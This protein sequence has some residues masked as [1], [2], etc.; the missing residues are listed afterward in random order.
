MKL[1]VVFAFVF[2]FAFSCVNSSVVCAP[3]LDVLVCFVRTTDSTLIQETIATQISSGETKLEIRVQPEGLGVVLNITSPEEITD[4]TIINNSAGDIYIE[5]YTFNSGVVTLSFSGYT[6]VV[7]QNLFFTYFPNLEIFEASEVGATSFPLFTQNKKLIE[8]NIGY[9]AIVNES[10]RVINKNAFAGL[11]KLS[12]LKIT[13]MGITEIKGGSFK[14]LTNLRELYLEYNEIKSLESCMF[15]GLENLLTMSLYGNGINSV[16]SNAFLGLSKLSKLVLSQNPSMQ[17]TSVTAL[18][19]LQLLQLSEQNSTSVLPE[20]IQQMTNLTTLDLYSVVFNCT[21][22]TEWLSK[23]AS[24]DISVSFGST[25]CLGD[26]QVASEPLL[27]SS[28]PDRSFQ[29]F[30]NSIECV[31]ENWNRVA[32]PDGCDCVYPNES[33]TVSQICNDTNECEDSSICQ[34]NCINTIGSYRCACLEGFYKMNDTLCVDINECLLAN[35]NCT[36]NCSNT[37][38][39]YECS[40]V[41]GYQKIGSFGCVDIN[42]CLLA[43]GNCTH[44]CS[45][46]LGSYECSCIVGYQKMGS[47]D[48]VDINECLLNNGNCTHICSNTLGSYECSCVVGYQK[49][50]S[51]GCIDINECLL[52]NGNCTHNCSNT[53]GSYEC[54]CLPGYMQFGSTECSL[55]NTCS[56]NSGGCHHNCIDSLDGYVCSCLEGF[57]VSLLNSSHCEV[58]AVTGNNANSKELSFYALFFICFLFLATI[59]LLF[60]FLIIL[61]LYSRKQLQ[62]V[63]AKLASKGVVLTQLEAKPETASPQLDSSPNQ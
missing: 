40:C 25:T 44:N 29:C 53:M 28:C 18:K 62:S 36:H 23:L 54:S 16:H 8:I 19:A 11:D 35:G 5:A 20:I 3:N 13:S 34:G 9:G 22:D 39:S 51:S 48:C 30:N 58:D 56:H 47:Y 43:N 42:E 55:P 1:T 32:T 38:G 7:R 37:L 57:K 21:C 10:N 41:V 46:S 49:M 24:F 50:G 4:W 14:D 12:F 6:I 33:Y 63:N 17:L 26:S 45:N 59:I 60:V 61:F 52:D 31:G 27:Y 15:D 2:T